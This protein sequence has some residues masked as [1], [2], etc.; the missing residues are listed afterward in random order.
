M[1]ELGLVLVLVVPSL[2]SVAVA[3]ERGF[4][5]ADEVVEVNWEVAP[6]RVSAVRAEG[7]N[8]VVVAEEVVVAVVEPAVVSGEELVM[9]ALDGSWQMVVVEVPAVVVMSLEALGWRCGCDCSAVSLRAAWLWR[10]LAPGLVLARA[11]VAAAAYVA[12]V[13]AASKLLGVAD[14]LVAASASVAAVARAGAE[15]G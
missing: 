1:P 3:L 4:G 13:G 2:D 5:V 6:G 15:G 7:Q 12:A 8:A 10:L 11:V 9:C 14:F